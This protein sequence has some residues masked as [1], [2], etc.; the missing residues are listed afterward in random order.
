MSYQ[1]TKGA[2]GKVD[3]KVDVPKDEFDQTYDQV[4]AALGRD[5]KIAGFRPGKAPKDVLVGHVGANKILNEAAGFLI[6][7]HLGEVFEKEKF[8]PID[9]P[10][11]SI[12]T[13]APGSAFSFTAS[14]TQKPQ[15]KIGDWRKIKIEKVKP[16]AIANTDVDE[17][18]KNIFEAWKKQ[19]ASKEPKEPEES[20]K[21]IYDAR[22][23]KIFLKDEPK[24]SEKS[25]SPSTKAQDKIDDNFAK[26]IGAR[27]LAHL[28]EL[29]RKDLETIVTDQVEAKVE[30]E[31]FEKLVEMTEVEV[32]EILVDDELNRILVRL[33]SQLE[34]QGRDLDSYLKEEKTTIDEL[35]TKWREQA[36]KNVKTTL[37]MDKIGRDEKVSVSQ[38]EVE[39]ALRGVGEANLT[40]EQ[41]ADMERYV[42]LS[43]FQAKTLDLVKKAV[44]L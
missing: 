41:K 11:I 31:L 2:K 10:K 7:K 35:K 14:F 43:I 4:L 16:K 8:F 44:A 27:D 36:E 9:S 21:F 17:S 24:K 20:R 12:S 5:A 19:K 6:N 26:A 32:P 25:G 28:K 34:Q 38:E 42:T 1:V 3:V 39:T 30:Q 23:E 40:D 15:I 22:G 33:S 13:L 37:V 29:V 18:I